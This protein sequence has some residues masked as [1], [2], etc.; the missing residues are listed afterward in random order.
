M[1]SVFC[2]CIV[3][4]M[5]V[6]HSIR[7][8]IVRHIKTKVYMLAWSD[9]HICVCFVLYTMIFI[10]ILYGFYTQH[11]PTPALSEVISIIKQCCDTM[12]M[13]NVVIVVVVEQ[14][15]SIS[16]KASNQHEHHIPTSNY[17][18]M[19]EIA[20]YNRVCAVCMDFVLNGFLLKTWF[21]WRA[22]INYIMHD[23]AAIGQS[24]RLVVF[25]IL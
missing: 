10:L 3:D 18:Q 22:T 23:G 2:L 19:Y 8:F 13:V 16:Q 24:V 17:I 7:N 15:C 5:R 21:S 11:T 4:R 12:M 25:L 1:F 6:W 9:I 20:Q 14:N